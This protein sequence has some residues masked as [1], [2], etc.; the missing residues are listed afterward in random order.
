M[1]YHNSILDSDLY[2]FSMQQGL[3]S[4]YPKVV[5]QYRFINRDK[6]EFPEGFAKRLTEIIE[7]FRSIYLQKDEKDFLREKC[8]YLS[9][10][11]LD[12]LEGYRYD[13]SEVKIE[14]KGPDLFITIIGLGYRTVLWEVPLMSVISELYFSLTDN[15]ERYDKLCNQK[16]AEEL[17]K[18]GVYYSE[19]GTR[20]RY[21]YFN[22]DKVISDLNEHGKGYFLGTSNV[23]LAMKHNLVPMGTVAHEWYSLHGAL[24]GFNHANEAANEAWVNVYE[25]DLGTALPDTFTSDV[26]LRSFNTKY[27]KL[28][29]GIRQDSGDPLC[30]VDKFVN[31]YNKLRINPHYKMA[32]F[33]DNLKS[34]QQIKKIH[35]HCLHK[36]ND[37]YGIGTWFSN[38]VGVKPLN[39]VIKL[40][41]C[42]FDGRWIDTVKLSDDKGKNTGNSNVV[43]LCK[44]ILGL[45]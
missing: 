39:I 10:V 19:F 45:E 30:F 1:F 15:Q 33:S 34:I 40:V 14:Q 4:L 8:W 28:F 11:Y 6:R 31:H 35:E 44:Q 22:Q 16:K 36:I 2:K 42:N 5:N 18:I 12:F 38:D 29:D 41:A 17:S 23:H 43:S 27:A 24:F 32:L 13:P 26:F 7:S 37:R 3:C 21:S 25:G 9:P 20:R